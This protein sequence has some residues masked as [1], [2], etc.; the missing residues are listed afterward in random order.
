LKYICK[1]RF[2]F[3][4]FALYL[5]KILRIQIR[6]KRYGFFKRD[7]QK[8]EERRDQEFQNIRE[9]LSQTGGYKDYDII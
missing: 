7:H 4:K 9:T 3:S 5:A 2:N 8:P 1:D 6:K